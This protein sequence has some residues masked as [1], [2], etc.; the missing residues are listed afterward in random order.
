MT[1]TALEALQNEC[2]ELPL[3]LRRRRQQLRYSIKILSTPD[4]PTSSVLRDHWANH[5]GRRPRT[6]DSNVKDFF[7]IYG[8]KIPTVNLKP[9]PDPPWSVDPFSVDCSLTSVLRKSDPE[10]NCKALALAMISGYSDRLHIYT[11]GSK[12]EEGHVACSVCVP[13]KNVQVKLRLSDKLSVFTAE[14]MAVAKA[15][16][17]AM[18]YCN[19]GESRN[20]AIFS[21]SLSVI[22]SLD[23]SRSHNRP[24]I[25]KEI[26]NLK[27][28]FTNTVSIAWIPSHVGIKGN[29]LAD[30][31]AKEALKHPSIDT[32]LPP[33]KIEIYDAID[34]Y[35]TQQWQEN[36]IK[37][38]IAKHNKTVQLN[39]SSK[40]KLTDPSRRKEVYLTR[41]RLGVC[42]LNHYLK[43]QNRHQT[44]LCNACGVAQTIE[45]YLMHC[46]G[47][48]I[49]IA[50][51]NICT[52]DNIP[53]QLQHILNNNKTLRAVY[54]NVNV[55]I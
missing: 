24:D 16:E 51:Q 32:V 23:S 53:F 25:F 52:K 47:N 50:V 11:D 18:D 12:D 2:G 20:I 9:E 43:I 28:S 38:S 35:I 8:W 19:A 21:D 30:R 6:I 4:H 22:Q 13:E 5:Y 49:S 27:K 1:G 10:L 33:D 55:C 48:N 31:L 37:S 36:W 54:D 29:E 42:R 3:A 14:L 41:L 40:M 45:H 46:R 26:I 7:E 34:E 39:V 17:L 15:L 44:G